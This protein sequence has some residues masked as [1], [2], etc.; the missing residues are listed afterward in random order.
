MNSPCNQLNDDL[1]QESADNDADH[2]SEG[3]TDEITFERLSEETKLKR[4]MEI[5]EKLR[6]KGDNLALRGYSSTMYTNAGGGLNPFTKDP[7]KLNCESYR[8]NANNKLEYGA[9]L[10]T[11]GL[12]DKIYYTEARL[13][14]EALKR[15][16]RYLHKYFPAVK[17]VAVPMSEQ[18]KKA[19]ELGKAEDDHERDASFSGCAALIHISWWK[20]L[21]NKQPKN[22]VA[23]RALELVYSPTGTTGDPSE[24]LVDLL[25][26]AVSGNK[27]ATPGPGLQTTKALNQWIAD[28]LKYHLHRKSKVT[29]LGDFNAVQFTCD[30]A[31]GIFSKQDGGFSIHKVVE[32]VAPSMRYANTA[33]GF[34]TK[35]YTPT[36]EKPPVSL[37]DYV[38]VSE[39]MGPFHFSTSTIIDANLSKTHF[40]HLFSFIENPLVQIPNPD[41]QA[42]QM[43]PEETPN[44]C[45]IQLWPLKQHRKHR[46]SKPCEE[47][48]CQVCTYS[49]EKLQAPEKVME[50][51][52]AFE[53]YVLT[54]GPE[55]SDITIDQPEEERLQTRE[56]GEMLTN[57]VFKQLITAQKETQT[58]YAR[59]P[60]IITT[61]SKPAKKAERLKIDVCKKILSHWNQ[62][63]T[64]FS[65]QLADILHHIYALRQY[66]KACI[67]WQTWQRNYAI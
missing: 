34:R 28:N 64:P 3:D 24:Y 65:T 63:P 22:E 9:K 44:H 13:T 12:V 40:V 29:L 60:R 8:P 62:L 67:T 30:R 66:A 38:V 17:I 55:R 31:S 23:G 33:K 56:A 16:R 35:T 61:H 58:D 5:D 48:K 36:A 1:H 25:V 42:A 53:A 47:K 26:Y 45:L 51:N 2:D 59:D 54:K 49:T 10:I 6:V 14:H 50:I 43:T 41:F 32:A 19:F 39:N 37:L 27:A 4:M 21:T 15:I 20:R 57:T 52:E 18:S 7:T 46:R 11:S